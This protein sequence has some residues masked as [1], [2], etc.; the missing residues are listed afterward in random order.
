MALKISGRLH[1]IGPVE[2][3]KEN[4]SKRDFIVELVDELPSG[5]VFTNYASFQ[6]INAGCSLIDSMQPGQM[7]SV[8]FTLRGSRYERDGQ[9]KCITNLNAYKVEM[10]GEPSAYTS[11]AQNAGPF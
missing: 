6:L 9:T 11:T 10:L 1:I 4:F 7:V 5:M 3:I 8:S 2:L